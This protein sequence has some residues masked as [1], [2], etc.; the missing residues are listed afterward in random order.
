MKWKKWLENWDMTS[1]KVNFKFLEMEWQPKE[2]DKN[3]AWELYIEMLTRI[4]TQQLQP[5]HG[6]E[7]TALTSIYNLFP[8]TREIIKR[9]GRDS[10]EFTKIAV[11]VLNQVVR[12][13][14]E[15]WHRELLKDAFEKKEKCAQFRRELAQLQVLYLIHI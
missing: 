15:K 12:P 2:P 9:N 13:F 6:D 7:K 8:L 1:L 10:I 11:V 4:T 5:E 14:T 3:A